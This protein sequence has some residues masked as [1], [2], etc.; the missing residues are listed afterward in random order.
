MAEVLGKMLSQSADGISPEPVTASKIV[1]FP[2][3]EERGK[4]N[5]TDEKCEGPTTN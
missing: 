2:R 4:N 5:V 3:W 1:E